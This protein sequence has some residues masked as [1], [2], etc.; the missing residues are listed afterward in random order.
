MSY[1]LNQYKNL[2]IETARK[3]LLNLNKDLEI[4]VSLRDKTGAIEDAFISAHSLKGQSFVMG[5]KSLGYACSILEDYFRKI[6]DGKESLETDKLK[7]IALMV[8][9]IS[10]SINQIKIKNAELDL[11]TESNRLRKNLGLDI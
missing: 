10:R 2:F 3:Y 6:K 1:N 11:A 7:L 5:Y 8:K 4:M 9:E